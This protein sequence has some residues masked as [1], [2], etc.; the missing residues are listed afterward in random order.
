[1]SL[2]SQQNSDNA[3]EFSGAHVLDARVHLWSARLVNPLFW[4]MKSTLQ[5]TY[6]PRDYIDQHMVVLSGELTPQQRRDT[7]VGGSLGLERLFHLAPT[8]KLFAN[9]LYGYTGFDSNQNHYDARVTTF[10]PD[11]YDYDQQSLG[12]RFTLAFG[13]KSAGPMLIDAG[14]TYSRRDYR[15]RVIQSFDGTYMKGKLYEIDQNI[16]FGFSYPITKSIRM[17]TTTSFGQSKSN[18]DYEAV[19]RYNYHNANYQVGFT[20]DY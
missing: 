6:S 16:D 1:V 19:Y 17:R 5:L 9:V 14:Y 3:R 11:Y 12:G 13:Q 4:K 20:Y 8:T 15:S 7:L 18:N 10:V 2:E